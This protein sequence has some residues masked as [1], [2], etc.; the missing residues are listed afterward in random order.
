MKFPNIPAAA[1]A[2]IAGGLLV[3]VVYERFFRPEPFRLP[4]PV[5]VALDSAKARQLRS[6]AYED[7]LTRIAAEAKAQEAAAAARA[8]AANRRAA[9]AQA[10]ADSLAAEAR[11]I[12]IVRTSPPDT[13]ADTW[14][15]AFDAKAAEANELRVIVSTDSAKIAFL[16]VQLFAMTAGRDSAVSRNHQTDQINDDLKRALAKKGECRLVP[17]TPIGCP[18]RVEAGATGLLLGGILGV[19][20]TR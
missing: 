19:A 1:W 8:A 20:L 15:R 9:L 12:E 14:H 4:P 16:R 17:H 6:D 11:R 18:T 10:S 3:L 5:Q 7:S 13:L 2:A